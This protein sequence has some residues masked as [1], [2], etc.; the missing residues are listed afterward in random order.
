MV[1]GAQYELDQADQT[2]ARTALQ[3][4]AMSG[5]GV[6]KGKGKKHWSNTVIWNSY[7][8]PYPFN[9]TLVKVDEVA[10]VWDEYKK[11]KTA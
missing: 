2:A 10:F 3:E 8:C 11:G 7:Y 4:S 1:W 6:A 9:L 5:K